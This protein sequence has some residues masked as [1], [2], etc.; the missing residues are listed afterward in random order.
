MPVARIREHVGNFY[1]IYEALGQGNL[2]TGWLTQIEGK[3]NIFPH[4]DY[5]DFGDF[6]NQSN[7]KVHY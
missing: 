1:C 4:I 7:G 2:K 6:V 5:R 3:N